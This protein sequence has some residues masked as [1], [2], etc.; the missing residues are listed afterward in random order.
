V[1]TVEITSRQNPRFKS[2][3]KLISSARD[4]RAEGLCVL[5]GEHL[6]SQ[7]VARGLALE[8]LIVSKDFADKNSFTANE[9]LV[10]PA[11]HIG[12][13][14]ELISPQN[15][16]AL[17]KIPKNP[18]V[19][20]AQLVPFSVLVLE[21]IQDPNNVGAL[22]RTAAAMGVREAWL[23]EGCAYAWSQKTLRA[24]QGAQCNIV[25]RENTE[26][27]S[28]LA[29]FNGEICV[30]TLTESTSLS[31]ANLSAQRIA[32]VV[33]NEGEGVSEAVLKLASVRVRIPMHAGV[34]S[35]NV[36]AA[37]AILLY[38]WQRQI[39]AKLDK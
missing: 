1:K 27:V 23:S 20:A 33:G 6:I 31:N 10:I 15:V 4:L 5:E 36:G 9:I 21:K 7:F 37:A 30:T 35:F 22:L 28:A 38:E 3:V 14:S 19:P 39:T 26:L 8:T 18:P 25:V 11:A 32:F 16:I 24:S 13:F 29:K 2:L 17:A 12:A 34:E